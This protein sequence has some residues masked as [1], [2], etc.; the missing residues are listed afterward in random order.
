MA[1]R[2]RPRPDESPLELA[3]CD[4]RGDDEAEPPAADV[5]ACGATDLCD[6]RAPSWIACR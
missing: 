5:A 1:D 2:K 3:P 4:A 6:W